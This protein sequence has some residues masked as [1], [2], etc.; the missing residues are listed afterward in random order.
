MQS[1]LLE[2]IA[3]FSH[4]SDQEC[5]LLL[6]DHFLEGLESDTYIDWDIVGKFIMT[7]YADR[8]ALCRL[9]NAAVKKNIQK[10]GNSTISEWIKKY[11]D[12]YLGKERNDNTFFEYISSEPEVKKLPVSEQLMIG[13]V[14]RIYDYLLVIPISGL[15]GPVNNILRFAM[16]P[17]SEEEKIKTFES[18]QSASVVQP[19][20]AK[21]APKKIVQMTLSEGLRTFEKLKDQIIT[22]RPFRIVTFASTVRPSIE[23]WI[24][25]YHQAYGTGT[26][27]EM[28]RFDYLFKSENARLLPNEER[29][30]VA[31][32]L[33]SLD[34]E[35]PLDIDPNTQ[36]IVF[37]RSAQ[38]IRSHRPEAGNP[39]RQPSAGLPKA[40]V[41]FSSP[42]KL[43]HEKFE[44]YRIT[45]FS[46][47]RF[48]E[49]KTAPKNNPGNQQMGKNVVN[50]KEL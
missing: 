9:F 38:E 44:P 26:H 13:R 31:A 10:I 6:R 16:R 19:Q 4:L 30:R 14:L 1:D 40:K 37:N 50:L 2:K 39:D 45:P 15:E 20:P 36:Q 3:N 18:V 47:R 41:S 23:H 27:S 17:N 32:I 48:S 42:Q 43:S 5:A 7:P 8:E 28:I 34:L 24:V 21:P 11:Q 35:L 25:D 12:R 22:S 49:Q 29:Q 46:E 33:K